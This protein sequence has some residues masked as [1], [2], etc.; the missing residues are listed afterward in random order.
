VYDPKEDECIE[1]ALAT[2]TNSNTGETFSTK[3]DNY[4]D[5]WL[6]NLKVGVYSLLIS[7]EGY[8]SKRMNSVCTEKDVNVGD[9]KLSK[10]KRR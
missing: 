6:H 1:G 9:I 8:H 5:F 7:K 10:R 3:T 2:L 4:G